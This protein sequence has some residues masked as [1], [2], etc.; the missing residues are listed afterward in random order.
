M[1]DIVH[2]FHET[3]LENNPTREPDPRRASGLA[4]AYLEEI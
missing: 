3:T 2:S 1:R 4:I